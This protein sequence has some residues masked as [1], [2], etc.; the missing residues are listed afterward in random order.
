MF[1]NISG[2]PPTEVVIIGAGTVGEF[3]ARSAIGLGANVKI[4][5]NS[6]TKLRSVQSHLGRT[7]YTSTLQPKNLIKALKRCDIAIGA[8]R[9]TNRAPTSEVTTH[10][11][12]TFEYN[13]IVHYC[14]P[15]IPARYSRSA[16][17]SISNMFTPYLL[18]IGDDGGIENALRF[19]RGLKNGLYFYH[20]IL[21]SKLVANWFDLK[22]SD[23][24]LLIF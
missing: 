21:T 6:I 5:D 9:G 22:Y 15:N 8:V 23:V 16:S 14:V 19:D 10:D 13:G 1:G 7:L 12:P 17:V 20:G 24:N 11:K 2:V 4:F 3:A 18:K